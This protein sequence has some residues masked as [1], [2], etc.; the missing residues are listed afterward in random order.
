MSQSLFS[1]SWYRVA[2][3]R[4]RLRNHAQIHR[5]IYR[6]GVWYVLQNHS[7]G[8]FHRFTPVANLIIGLMDGRRTLRE[9]WDIACNRL[10]DEVPTQDE[11][12]KLLSDLHRADVLQSDA[13]PDLHELQQRRKKH[14]RMRWKQYIGN[15]LSLRIPL[16]DPDRMLDRL[17][18]LIKPVLGWYAAIAWLLVVGWALVLIGM[19]WTELSGDVVDRVF[20]VENLLLI[21]FVFPL[22]KAMHEFGHA[23]ATKVDGGEVHE[24]GIMLLVLMPIPYVDASGAT[25]F[26][27]KKSRMLVGGAGMLVEIFIA[28]LAVFA[29]VH[30]EPGVE[31][32]IAYNII[33]VA[34]VS[35]LLFNANPLLR[36]DGYYILSDYLEIPNLAQRSNEY[37]GYLVNRHLFG[38]EGGNSP[39]VASGESG[40]FVS[41]A[42]GSFLYRMFMMV[43]IA[44]LVASQFFFVGVILAV[45]AFATMLVIP[46]VKKLH[47]LFASP[48]LDT[49]RK[50]ALVSSGIIVL[51]VVVIFG[52][53]PAP[54]ST[55]A[56]GVI[57]APEEA[58][59]R[60]TVDCFI[61][62]VVAK[63]GQQVRR[64]DV[65]IEC[66]DPELAARTRVLQAQLDELEARYNASII[67][68]RVQAGMI[69]E[70]KAHMVAALELAYKRQAELELRSPS[71]GVFVMADVQNAPGKF[72]QRGEV[73]AYVS[74]SAAS[75]VRVV[76]AQAAENLVSKR[77]RKVEIRP[78]GAIGN[79]FQARIKREVPAATDELPSMTLSL[80]GGGKIGLDPSK[81]GDGKALEKLFVLDLDSISGAPANYIG[82]RIYVRFEHQPEP[83][84]RQWYRDVRRIFLKRFNV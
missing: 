10:G 18:P 6:G 24:M 65:L 23:I 28:A 51:L 45:W 57:W 81:Q 56:E 58:Q 49:H 21:W 67:A 2:D 59:V 63:P 55:R 35:T 3:I 7:T 14:V 48:R 31:R 44:L 9:I 19:H 25:A 79:P 13:P 11:V 30:L 37:L 80:Q 47:Y 39:V 20:S 70:Q 17:L 76:V 46:A 71:D 84:A 78:S 69:N 41:Y 54:S 83:L 8:K 52:W 1:T 68:K 72:T 60:S 50:R 16:F 82:G 12:I 4:P 64:G 62:R 53:L 61:A 32:A 26:R 66:E 15:P 74:N 75:N 5:H 38:V 40:W 42:I 27:D 33:L 29:W 36:Y 77:T 22:I 34:G 73:L 43:S